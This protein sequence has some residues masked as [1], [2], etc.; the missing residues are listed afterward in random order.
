MKCRALPCVGLHARAHTHTCTVVLD[1]VASSAPCV[2]LWPP[3]TCLL[4]MVLCCT[5]TTNTQWRKS[6][7]FQH[8]M[9]RIV[10]LM[11]IIMFRQW[12]VCSCYCCC[13]CCL[14]WGKRMG[15]WVLFP[16]DFVVLRAL[17]SQT[18]HFCSFITGRKYT[19]RTPP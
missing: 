17:T 11:L 8:S 7:S 2:L 4:I 15:V 9:K 19:I 14:S 5:V 12:W 1:L 10:I 6:E 18:A 3:G 16:A 13:C